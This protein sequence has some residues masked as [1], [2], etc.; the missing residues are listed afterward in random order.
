MNNGKK[1]EVADLAPL[2]DDRDGRRKAKLVTNLSDL[3][4]AGVN[5]ETY[6]LQPGEVLEFP[7]FEDMIVKSQPVQIGSTTEV[8]LVACWRT[9][10]GRTE[11][12][13]YWF[14]L[15]SLASRDVHQNPIYE[16]WYELGNVE[17]RLQKLAECGAIKGGETFNVEMPEF[18]EGKRVTREIPNPNG[19]GTLITVDGVVTKTRCKIVKVHG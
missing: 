18:K 16:E 11:K 7:K 3:K 1:I 10:A 13:P 14:N 17:A 12:K 4:N 2:F 19:D 6:T 5:F 8:Y 9:R 15:N